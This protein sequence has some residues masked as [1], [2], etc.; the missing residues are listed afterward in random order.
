MIRS[1]LSALLLLVTSCNAIAITPTFSVIREVHY[2]VLLPES[3]SCRMIASTGTITNYI[4]ELICVLPEG[5]QNGRYTITANPHK[6]IRVKILPNL[7]NGN[8]IIFNPYVELI[9]E[10]EIGKVI[11][12]NIGFVEIDSGVTGIVEL[13]V[14]GDLTISGTF[15]FGQTVNF[16]FAD[17]IEWHELP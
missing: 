11:S 7:D 6:T 12:N 16:S 3:G 5:V 10:G 13:Y 1:I 14:G 8:G 15:G 4:G 17:G 2:G 9:S